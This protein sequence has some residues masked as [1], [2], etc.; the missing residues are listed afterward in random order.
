MSRIATLLS[1]HL[2]MFLHIS[3]LLSISLSDGI[4]SIL[5][6]VMELFFQ[7]VNMHTLSQPT[8][9]SS[10]WYSHHPH[11]PRNL[12]RWASWC[13]CSQRLSEHNLKCLSLLRESLGE[14][15]PYSTSWLAAP[16]WTIITVF[17]SRSTAR[18]QCYCSTTLTLMILLQS[19]TRNTNK[20][21]NCWHTVKKK[22]KG[23]CIFY[24][25]I[26]AFGTFALNTLWEI[27]FSSDILLQLLMICK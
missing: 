2:L 6:F 7:A 21:D 10:K 1:C 17:E 3:L 8:H 4:R 25:E 22:K 5:L 23:K 19:L 14:E 13:L 12:L 18:E 26:S 24:I 11:K 16:R 20:L 9:S 15:E 27:K